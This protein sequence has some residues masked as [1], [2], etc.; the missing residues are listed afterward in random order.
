VLSPVEALALIDDR[1]GVGVLFGVPVL[2]V[3][4]DETRACAELARRASQLPCVFVAVGA[5]RPGA[6]GL[7]VEVSGADELAVLVAAIERSPEASVALVQLL[8][9]GEQ[10]DLAAALVAESIVYGLLQSGARF[11]TWLADQPA[12]A[13]LDVDAPVAVERVGATLTCTLARP[14]VRNAFDA[15][16][17]DALVEALAMASADPTIARVELRGVGADFCSGGDL[18]EFGHTPDPLVGHLVRTTRSAASAMASIAERT[19]AFVHGACIGAGIEL[20]AFAG[21][22]VASP[23]TRISLPEVEMGLIPGAGGTVSLARRMGRQRTAWMA[24]T[25][26]TID[27]ATALD[28]G[29]VDQIEA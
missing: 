22:L 9:L 19:T 12:R 20:P 6:P 25:G 18:S 2:A 16:T 3:A 29:L 21:R 11:R 13:H 5:R 10:L 24:L 27:A 14:R 28:W 17:R 26:A 15:A 23:D 8:R 1:D 4:V 7:D